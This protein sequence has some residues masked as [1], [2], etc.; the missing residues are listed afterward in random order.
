MTL[1]EFL[2]SLSANP[3]YLLVYFSI[4][5]LTALI[6]WLLGK[7]EGNTS[8]WKYL[9]ASLI[10]M[11]CVPGIFAVGLNLYAFLFEPRKA[12]TL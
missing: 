2:D 7:G 10:Y 8:P 12:Y 3:F 11:V 1:K 5:P 4:I 9:Y 6:A